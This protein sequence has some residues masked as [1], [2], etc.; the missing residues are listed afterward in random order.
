MLK[1]SNI[2][3]IDKWVIMMNILFT[4]EVYYMQFLELYGEID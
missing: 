1:S 2:K 4:S 3:K